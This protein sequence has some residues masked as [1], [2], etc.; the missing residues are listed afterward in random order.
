MFVVDINPLQTINLLHLV[1]EI[2]LQFSNAANIEDLLR[3][4]ETFG[5]LLTL[6][7]VIP[8]LDDQVLCE[9]DEVFLFHASH[10]VADNHDPLVLLNAAEVDNSVDLRNLSGI[11]RTTGFKELGDAG[12]TARD[13]LRLDGAAWQ[14]RKDHTR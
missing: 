14:F 5:H 10:F 6:H 12:Q 9:R 2:F 8:F 3:D 1:D 4:N 13:V 11:F 7:H